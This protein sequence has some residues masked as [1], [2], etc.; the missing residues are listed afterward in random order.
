MFS[1]DP[2]SKDCRKTVG[3]PIFARYLLKTCVQQTGQSLD[4]YFQKL[5]S[6]SMN[7]N[8][9][10]VSAIQHKEE[11][12]RDAFVSGIALPEIRQR[13]LENPQLDLQATLE[14]ARSLDTARNNSLQFD[15]AT[16]SSSESCTTSVKSANDSPR[17]DAAVALR[18]RKC[19]YCGNTYH[20]RRFCPAKEVQCFRC[21]KVIHFA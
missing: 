13:I 9:V 14:M 19:Q 15:N 1:A 11:A 6:P 7:C 4:D 21:L 16:P 5:K 8:F 2:H 12:V 20:A 18:H 3:F 17:T 10:A